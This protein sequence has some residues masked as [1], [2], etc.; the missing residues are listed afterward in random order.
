MDKSMRK[1]KEITFTPCD[2]EYNFFSQLELKLEVRF[3]EILS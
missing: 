1:P 2:K 3:A